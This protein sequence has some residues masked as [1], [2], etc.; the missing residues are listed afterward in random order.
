MSEYFLLTSVD[1]WLFT[2]L[3][4]DLFIAVILIIALRFFYG[5][6]ANVHAT[7]EL[8][9]RDNFAFG[10]SFS[11]GVLALA[12]MLMGVLS[13]EAEDDL[14][15]ESGMVLAYGV[16]GIILIKAGRL[17]QD[18]LVLTGI[19][20]QDEI[21]KGNIAA[22]FVDMANILATGLVLRA[23]ILWVESASVMG[24]GVVLIAFIFVQL[25][26]ALVTRARLFI[27][28]KRHPEGCLQE[29]F[30][31]GNIAISL[32]YLGHLVGVALVM[33][34]A[35]GLIIYNEKQLA[36]AVAAWLMLTV[37]FS[38][39]LSLLAFISRK[40]ILS[41]IDVVDE[42]DHQKNVAVGAIEGSIFI[43]IALVMLSLFS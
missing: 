37:L 41:G 4:I 32:R 6:V 13:G 35:S 1:R 2:V 25:L 28:E 18:K 26:L 38:I 12:F 19:S 39:L 21:N 8:A 27:Y 10:L 3:F 43:A 5:L 22:A 36:A 16:L 20:L 23:V 14:L 24:L 33:S 17:I 15:T 40:V 34:A 30:R 31:S 29:A 9:E 7:N 42:V 11:G